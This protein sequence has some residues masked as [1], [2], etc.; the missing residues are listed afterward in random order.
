M[1]PKTDT[2][3]AEERARIEAEVLEEQRRAREK[4]EKERL[5]RIGTDQE[6]VADEQEEVTEDLLMRQLQKLVDYKRSTYRSSAITNPGFQTGRPKRILPPRARRNP[7][8]IYDGFSLDELADFEPIAVSN[9]M[10]SAEDMAQIQVSLEMA[11]VPT[12]DVSSILMQAAIHC[13]DVSSSTYMDARGTFR[14]SNGPIAADT[15]YSILKRDAETL[16]RVCRLYA[17]LTWN[18]MIYHQKPPSD[19]SAM[20]FIYEHRFAAFDC[21][22]YVENEAAIKP[23][24]GLIRRPTLEEKM[25]A[26]AYKTKA[27]DK[28]NRNRTFVNLGTEYTGGRLGPE[29]VRNHN[30]ANNK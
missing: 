19:W 23:R 12:E 25:A 5:D 1:P 24:D 3:I 7:T 17:K 13:K 26:D 29:I 30:N 28:A 2:E 18:Y 10:A 4:A 27:L 14:T 21:L 11:G 6:E 22:D 15:V 16:R 8:N 9:N 20:G